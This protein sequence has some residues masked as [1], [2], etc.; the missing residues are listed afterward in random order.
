MAKVKISGVQ[1]VEANI[2]ATFD[3]VIKSKAMKNEI[4]EF[5]VQ[6]IQAEA[7]RTKPLNEDRSF[8]QLTENTVNRRKRL[9]TV[10]NTQ[11]TFKPSRS[12]L[13]FTGQLIDAIFYRINSSNEVVIDVRSSRRDPIQGIRGSALESPP[14]NK[15]LQEELIGRGFLLYSAEGIKSEPRIMSRI[16][17]IV[18]KFV[19]RAI[20]VN[21]NS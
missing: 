12:N 4:G 20:K 6:R 21:F 2:K 8:P 7:R 17:N 5:M 19:R 9:A 10:N 13:T 1:A 14:T 15:A 3:K 16:N 18:K 11:A